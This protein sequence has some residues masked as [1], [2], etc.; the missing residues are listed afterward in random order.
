MDCQITSAQEATSRAS[1]SRDSHSGDHFTPYRKRKPKFSLEE[2]EILAEEIAP[3]HKFLFRTPT[4]ESATAKNAAK[5]EKI[6]KR[7]NEQGVY[8]RS[9]SDIKKRW[10]DLKRTTKSKNKRAQPEKPLTQLSKQE[11]KRMKA[12]E[13]IVS[14]SFSTSH[15]ERGPRAIVSSLIIGPT[16]ESPPQEEEQDREDEK[17]E[18]FKVESNTSQAA[19]TDVNIKQEQEDHLNPT[20]GN[21]VTAETDHLHSPCPEEEIP[22]VDL[23]GISVNANSCPRLLQRKRRSSS[24]EKERKTMA[25]QDTVP[26][27]MYQRLM[28]ETSRAK[29]SILH[30]A[31]KERNRRLSTLEQRLHRHG[32]T[33][34]TILRLV[35]ELSRR[36]FQHYSEMSKLTKSVWQMAKIISDIKN[37]ALH[38]NNGES[39]REVDLSPPITSASSTTANC[40][41]SARGIPRLRH[42]SRPQTD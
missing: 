32:Q 20:F 5:W 42:S 11:D 28:L 27:T 16:S 21:R 7:I 2:L 30:N 23:Q 6:L 13:E 26:M 35:S 1:T 40:V 14:S 22:A 12:I 25:A 36:S 3:H 15:G 19:H 38:S 33:Q 37:P 9:L 24:A 29:N 8:P 31:G 4:S 34:K 39:C 41:E 18:G 10:Y 17:L